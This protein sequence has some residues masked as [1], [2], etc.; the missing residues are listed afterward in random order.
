MVLSGFASTQRRNRAAKATLGKSGF[1]RMGFFGIMAG[2]WL[3]VFSF[4]SDIWYAPGEI[5]F[6]H[7]SKIC[8]RAG[9]NLRQLGICG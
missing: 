6:M 2:F 9:L 4:Y 7:D 8:R 1:R 5:V 3:A